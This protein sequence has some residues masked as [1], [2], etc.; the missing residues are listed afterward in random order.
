MFNTTLRIRDLIKKHHTGEITADEAAELEAWRVGD[1]LNNSMFEKLMDPQ[2][3]QQEIRQR[4][5]W[6]AG[7]QE[8]LEEI[9]KGS[10]K[11][12]VVRANWWR[13]VAAAAIIAIMIGVYLFSNSRNNNLSNSCCGDSNPLVDR[14]PSSNNARLTL[15]DG[16]VIDLD[17]TKPGIIARQGNKSVIKTEDGKLIYKT[18]KGLLSM[19]LD[20]LEEYSGGPYPILLADGSKIFLN[21]RSKLDFPENFGP[22]KRVVILS[23]EAYFEIQKDNL[24]PFFVIVNGQE[25]RVTGT[26]FTV[27]AYADESYPVITVLEGPVQVSSGDAEA[28]MAF[29]TRPFV[30][31]GSLSSLMRL[32]AHRYDVQIQYEKNFNPDQFIISGTF[33]ENQMLSEVITRLEMF[34][35]QVRLEGNKLIVGQ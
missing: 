6:Q 17:K 33:D 14:L 19:T 22:G 30:N 8:A 1:P 25:I 27:R 16:R 18:E 10:A 31:E 35:I 24:R 15:S 29:V 11:T 9:I 13:I 2:F 5:S 34:G 21:S 7:T 4:Y 20:S 23:G 32:L 26:R 28:A 12:K 3:L